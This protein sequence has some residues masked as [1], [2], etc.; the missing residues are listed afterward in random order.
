[1]KLIEIKKLNSKLNLKNDLLE[2]NYKELERFSHVVSHDIKSPLNNILGFTELLKEEHCQVFNQEANLYI[3]LIKESAEKLKGYIDATLKAYKNGSLSS[4]EKEFFYLNSILKEGI[5]L[6][7]PK[8]EYEINLPEN[9]EIFNYKSYFEQIF[10][11]LISNAIKYNDKP[12]VIIDI[13]VRIEGQFYIIT[14]KDN[15]IGIENDKLEKIFD[16]FFTLEKV[17]RFNNTG[18][19]IGLSSV[20]TLVYRCDGDIQVKSV[21]GQGTE[22]ILKFKP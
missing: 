14:V 13:T 10:L 5:K 17:D 11:N 9:I 4:D 20:K 21:V 1:M 12:K 16:M 15:G 3:D 22:F 2:E 19:G 6:L 8:N 7:N 18:T